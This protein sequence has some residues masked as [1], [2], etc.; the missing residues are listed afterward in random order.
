MSGQAELYV[1]THLPWD[2]VLS[3]ELRRQGYKAA[4]KRLAKAQKGTF[5]TQGSA[6]DCSEW[7]AHCKRWS[8]SKGKMAIAVMAWQYDPMVKQ[9]DRAAKQLQ[10][11]QKSVKDQEQEITLLRQQL[12][13]QEVQTK[14]LQSFQRRVKGQEQEITLLRQQLQD[15]EEQTWQLQSTLKLSQASEQQLAV[16]MRS[17]DDQMRSLQQ[18]LSEQMK[19]NKT[20]SLKVVKLSQILFDSNFPSDEDIHL[21]TLP[22][23]KEYHSNHKFLKIFYSLGVDLY[24]IF[25]LVQT[26][27]P[28]KSLQTV[29]D[30]REHDL[31]LTDS[32]NHANMEAL[33]QRFHKCMSTA[34]G[35]AMK[36]YRVHQ[37][38]TQRNGGSIKAYGKSNEAP[39]INDERVLCD[40]L[41]NAWGKYVDLSVC[42][43]TSYGDPFSRVALKYCNQKIQC[44]NCG[45][46]GHE[47]ERCRRPGGGDEVGPDKCYTCGGRGHWARNCWLYWN[48]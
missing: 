13:D 3:L 28:Q 36:Q 24:R 42:L 38:R 16:E 10:Q 40:V 34:L 21:A 7:W 44:E 22:D 23:L 48:R 33:L 17:K 37:S 31:C 26:K 46:Y 18:E 29:K 25:Q 6:A 47:W 15:Q 39:D 4:T 5:P 9:R 2:K 20:I 45:N 1:P 43:F 12:Q 14:Q 30:L 32:L 27:F 8:V 35:S 41:Q 11:L 19:E